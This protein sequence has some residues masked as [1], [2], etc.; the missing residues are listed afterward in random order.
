MLNTIRTI[1]ILL[2]DLFLIILLLSAIVLILYIIASVI[3]ADA[4]AS[5]GNTCSKCYYY[6]NGF[7][8]WKHDRREPNETCQQWKE[9]N[10][11]H[12]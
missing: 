7:C 12:D 8:V 3:R 5:E 10:T 2:F 11:N 1:L 9:G 6:N 4:N